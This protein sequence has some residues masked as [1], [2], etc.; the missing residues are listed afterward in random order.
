[1]TTKQYQKQFN[2]QLAEQL[3]SV[4]RQQPNHIPV[5]SMKYKNASK[6]LVQDLKQPLALFPKKFKLK[7]V[8]EIIQKQSV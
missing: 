5:Y 3:D 2:K 1:M 4:R 7:T 6:Y 8:Y